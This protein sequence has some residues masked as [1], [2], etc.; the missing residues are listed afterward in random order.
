MHEEGRVEERV[1]EA[2]AREA[3]ATNSLVRDASDQRT[4]RAEDGLGLGSGLGPGSEPHG[5]LCETHG[6]A[7]LRHAGG[8]VPVAHALLD[9]RVGAVAGQQ[10]RGGEECLQHE[11]RAPDGEREAD[12]RDE[13]LVLERLLRVRRPE[14]AELRMRWR[15]R[16]R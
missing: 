14:P 15:V 16:W 12:G 7:E 10:L 6:P 3:I 5:V 13:R 8:R 2:E 9:L 4:Q 11:D 1:A